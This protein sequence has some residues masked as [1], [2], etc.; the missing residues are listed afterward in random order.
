MPDGRSLFPHWV[1]PTLLSLPGAV[2]S[3][4]ALFVSSF[5][6]TIGPPPLHLPLSA[7][8]CPF[9]FKL[10]SY[11]FSL[12]F[13]TS[14][15]L[16]CHLLFN[17]ITLFY[18]DENHFWTWLIW[19]KKKKHWIQT[20]NKLTSSQPASQLHCH[21]A[22]VPGQCPQRASQWAQIWPTNPRAHFTSQVGH[23]GKLTATF[24]YP[25]IC[26]RDVFLKAAISMKFYT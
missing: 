5:P 10:K 6:V 11:F 8:R 3:H 23:N 13:E 24:R 4:V 16:S 12:A 19:E 18:M 25:S 20:R 14:H 26:V 1:R 17:S 2:K 22:S 9:Q 7:A 21:S 15:G